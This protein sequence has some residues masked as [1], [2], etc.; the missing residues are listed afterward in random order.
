MTL[1]DLLLSMLSG[2]AGIGPAVYLA[3]EYIPFMKRVDPEW[4]RWIVAGLSGLLGVGAWALALW[5]GYVPSPPL[6]TPDYVLSAVW[7]YGV[8]TGFI[9]FTSAT[10]IHGRLELRKA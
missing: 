4:K 8:M 5:L 2:S 9:A 6:F 7:S 3:C 1:K 10:L